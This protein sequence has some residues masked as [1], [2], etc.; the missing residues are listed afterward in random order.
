MAEYWPHPHS[1]ASEGACQFHRIAC[2]LFTTASPLP[3]AQYSTM[4]VASFPGPAQLFV[5]CSTETARGPGNE[6]TMPVSRNPFI[7]CSRDLWTAEARATGSRFKYWIC[8]KFWREVGMAHS[9][10]TCF[11]AWGLSVRLPNNQVRVWATPY[12]P[13]PDFPA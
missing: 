11:T 3:H 1:K 8:C 4:P 13:V 5:A 12:T 2:R 6:A 9:L 10:S 7:D